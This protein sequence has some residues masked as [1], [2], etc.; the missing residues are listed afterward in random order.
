MNLVETGSVTS[1]VYLDRKSDGRKAS[2]RETLVKSDGV[3]DLAVCCVSGGLSVVT[4]RTG[5]VAVFEGRTSG[6]KSSSDGD[7][8]KFSFA[9]LISAMGLRLWRA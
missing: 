1:A 2:E 5:F 6:K 7:P 3:F 8:L 9:L 4:M